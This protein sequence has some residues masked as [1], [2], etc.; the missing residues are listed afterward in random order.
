MA[1]KTIVIDTSDFDLTAQFLRNKEGEISSAVPE[2]AA[3][4]LRKLPSKA[5]AEI[6]RLYAI[7]ARKLSGVLSTRRSSDAVELVGSGQGMS[8]VTFGGQYGGRST[9]GATVRVTQ[10]RGRAVVLGSFIPKSIPQIFEREKLPSGARVGRYPIK[11]LW[12]PSGA[13]MLKREE[14]VENITDEAD[15]VM[16]EKAAK[17]MGK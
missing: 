4:L 1:G 10:S 16:A 14:V 6:R 2:V 13:Q 7:P 9:P 5:K 8:L 12:G 15:I 3:E 17:L 11:K